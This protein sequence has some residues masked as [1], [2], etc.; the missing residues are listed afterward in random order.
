M[1]TTAKDLIESLSDR[2]IEIALHPEKRKNFSISYIVNDTSHCTIQYY[3][4]SPHISCIEPFSLALYYSDV[5]RCASSE[6]ERSECLEKIVEQILLI[7]NDQD[8]AE[9][10]VQVWTN[11]KLYCEGKDEMAFLKCSRL[12]LDALSRSK[13][14]VSIED[15]N[16]LRALLDG[17][18]YKS[19]AETIDNITAFIGSA[20]AEMPEPVNNEIY[21][22]FIDKVAAYAREAIEALEEEWSFLLF[23]ILQAHGFIENVFRRPAKGTFDFNYPKAE[24]GDKKYQK[25]LAEAYRTGNGVIQNTKLAEFWE[26]MSK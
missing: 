3:K 12:C 14:G 20:E 18:E 5:Y 26:N 7:E 11:L 15:L 1:N 17:D 16:N 9:A 6:E 4:N 8:K 10:E 25:L 23:A 21:S 2:L 13:D 24:K 22:E 19:V